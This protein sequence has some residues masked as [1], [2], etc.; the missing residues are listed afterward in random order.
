LYASCQYKCN[1]AVLKS[2]QQLILFYIFYILGYPGVF[3]LAT[4]TPGTIS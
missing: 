3:P 4:S 1:P 2:L